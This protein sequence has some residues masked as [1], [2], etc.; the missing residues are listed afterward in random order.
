[1]QQKAQAVGAPGGFGRAGDRGRP[2]LR[3]DAAEVEVALILD[4]GGAPERLGDQALHVPGIGLE[5]LHEAAAWVQ[6]EALAAALRRLDDMTLVDHTMHPPQGGGVGQPGHV[7]QRRQR[8][9]LAR[10]FTLD[11]VRHDVP[12][13]V[14]LGRGDE[15]EVRVARALE[16]A[17]HALEFVFVH[18]AGPARVAE[19]VKSQ[20]TS[21]K[22]SVK[23]YRSMSVESSHLLNAAM[24]DSFTPKTASSER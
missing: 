24:S 20:S 16:E 19:R 3:R 15:A 12:G 23:P 1:M 4:G 13:R 9:G 5:A 17:D 14:R 11:Q 2:R 8:H 10:K 21:Q 18:G 6:R 22:G 7:H